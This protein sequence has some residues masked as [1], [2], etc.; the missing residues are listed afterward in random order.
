MK[1]S[2]LRRVFGSGAEVEVE[3]MF[4]W[5]VVG[6]MQRGITDT[7]PRKAARYKAWRVD[8]TRARGGCGLCGRGEDR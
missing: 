4:V 5:R 6:N 2:Y 8:A 7:N 1:I 3:F